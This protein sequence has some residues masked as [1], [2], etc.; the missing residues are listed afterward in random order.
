[1]PFCVLRSAKRRVRG[2]ALTEA[3]R[4]TIKIIDHKQQKFMA[5]SA[6]GPE[7]GLYW[8]KRLERGKNALC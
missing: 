3:M 4:L 2:I 5:L 6:A 8:T 7:N 1:M